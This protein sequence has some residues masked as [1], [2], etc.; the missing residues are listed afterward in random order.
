MRDLIK[1]WPRLKQRPTQN[2]IAF[3]HVLL[4]FLDCRSQEPKVLFSI[5]V[6]PHAARWICQPQIVSLIRKLNLQKKCMFLWRLY[7]AQQT[8]RISSPTDMIWNYGYFVVV[9]RAEISSGF[10]CCASYFYIIQ[11][12]PNVSRRN[13]ARPSVF[14]SDTILREPDSFSCMMLTN[15][16]TCIFIPPRVWTRPYCCFHRTS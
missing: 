7:L 9:S 16:H 10:T 1:T 2:R 4:G 6:A 5:S 3:Y 12:G 15:A 13:V 11:L 14:K 8:I